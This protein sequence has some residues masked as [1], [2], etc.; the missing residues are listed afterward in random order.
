MHTCTDKN[1]WFVVA[2]LHQLFL[3]QSKKV[4]SFDVFAAFLALMGGNYHH[5]DQSPFIAPTEFIL[6]EKN[7]RILTYLV[8]LF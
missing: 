1:Y 4:I 5:I 6:L 8:L 7:V 3:P 2:E